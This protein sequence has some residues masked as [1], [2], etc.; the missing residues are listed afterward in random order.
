MGP[1]GIRRQDGKT[2]RRS[3]DRGLDNGE[4]NELSVVPILLERLAEG[5]T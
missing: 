4:S 3:H 5:A 2:S 1:S